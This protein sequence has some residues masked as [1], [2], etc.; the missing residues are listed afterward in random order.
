MN[1]RIFALLAAVML[2][3]AVLAGCGS[4]DADRIAQLEAENE[5]LKAQV[6]DLSRQLEA[7]GVASGLS[8]WSFEALAWSGSNGANITFTGI[9]YEY[10]E[11]QTATFSVWLEGDLIK[12]AACIW[13][14]DAYTASA[15]L[16]IADGYCY[17]CTITAPNGSQTEV[18]LNT[19][20]KPTAPELIDL[21]ASLTSYCSMMVEAS[22]LDGSTLT[23]EEGYIQAQL[24]RIS[25]DG[26]PLVISG[27]QAV[28]TFNGSEVGRADLELI[29][30]GL[31]G[32]YSG[33]VAGIS[34]SVP[35]MKDDEQLEL[36]MELTLSDGQTM[37]SP[38]GTWFCYDGD[39]LLVVG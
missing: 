4:G 38:A 7:A 22:T 24:P 29:N 36:T 20:K 25:R 14:G 16:N 15:D 35:D 10:T 27:A 6:E 3:C 5:Q 19:P 12:E 39:L 23:L 8:D 32:A 11:G 30:G 9:P 1:R 28:L 17:Y 31:E 18:E 13:D 26:N 34:F 33:S 21:E 2:L 37:T